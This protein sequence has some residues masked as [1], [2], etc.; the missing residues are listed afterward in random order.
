MDILIVTQDFPPEQGGIQTYVLEL[1]KGFLARGHAVRVICPGSAKDPDPLP[2]LKDLV[3][4]PGPSSFLWV[5]LLAYL[6]GYLRRNPGVTHVL[7]A[8]WQSAVPAA[9]LLRGK[10]GDGNGAAGRRKSYCLVHGRELLTSVFGPLAPA[11]MRR[12]FR[13]LDG[14]FPNSNAVLELTRAKAAPACPLHLVHPG[15]DPDQYRPADPAFLRQRYGLDGAPVIVSITRMVARKNLGRLIEAL[16]GVRAAVPGAT[17]VLGGTGPQRETLMK[18]AADLG[19]G[20][21]VRFPGRVADGEMAA[22]YSLAD[23]FALPSLSVGKDVEG[24]GIV[25]LEAGAC[26]VPVLGGLGGGVPDAVADGETGLLVDPESTDAI[27]DA[28]IRLLQD[29]ET[30][31]AMGLRARVRVERGF[32]WSAAADRVLGLIG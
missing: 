19:L 16:P 31:K 5:P 17:L 13:S 4:L 29:R 25:Y 23:V 6:P 9:L 1:A 12:V 8:Q 7:Y 32:T 14:A 30:S 27:R 20:D 22:H 10:P 26:E 11:F 2:G 15:V 3:R 18:Q 21:A 24:F 28:L